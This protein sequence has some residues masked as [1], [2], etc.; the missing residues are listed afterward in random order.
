MPDRRA[1]GW[2]G[3]IAERGELHGSTAEA[4]GLGKNGMQSVPGETEDQG[5]RRKG[6]GSE[7][8]PADKWYVHEG[9]R[10]WVPRPLR[11]A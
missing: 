5:G 11:L 10:M 9:I 7:A 3:S 2:A 4:Q 1:T 6:L 8:R